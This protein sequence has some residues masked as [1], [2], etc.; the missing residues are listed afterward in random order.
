M[1]AERLAMAVVDG[2][3]LFLGVVNELLETL[4]LLGFVAIEVELGGEVLFGED[5]E[6]GTDLWVRLIDHEGLVG[7]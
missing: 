4:S 7:A 3:H 1:L 6:G 5:P 2:R